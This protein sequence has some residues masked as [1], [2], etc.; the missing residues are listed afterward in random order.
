MENI[1]WYPG[2]MAKTKR[3]IK[4]M[5][6]VIDIIY[7]VVDARIPF[8]SKINDLDE[9]IKNKPKILIMTKMDLC[10]LEETEKWVN[11]YEKQNYKVIMVDL[12]NNNNIDMIIKTTNQL[13]TPLRLKPGLQ[14]RP[15]RGLVI[16]IPNVGKSTLINRLAGSKKTKVANQ[17]GITKGLDWYKINEYLYLVDSPG[18]LWPKLENNNSTYNLCA[19]MAIKQELIPTMDISTYILQFLIQ[20][21]PES[22]KERYQINDINNEDILITYD[23]IGKKRGCLIKGGEVNYEQV[24]LLIIKD[25]NEGKLGLITLDQ[26]KKE[27]LS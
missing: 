22:L 21:Y 18:L 24:S 10:D 23:V 4:E 12:L 13:L 3:L 2:H 1:N 25:L 26:Y 17:P 20:Y 16:G 11:Y 6:G 8:S 15:I 27:D 19:L 9:Y 14:K 7:E 5:M